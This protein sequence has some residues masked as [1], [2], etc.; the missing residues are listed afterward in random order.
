MVQTI[1]F[2]I[3]NI[4]NQ[5]RGNK[6]CIVM[7]G[8]FDTDDT[9]ARMIREVCKEMRISG[10]ANEAVNESVC[11]YADQKA[12]IVQ[13]Q[14]FP[15]NTD[16]PSGAIY[17]KSEVLGTVYPTYNAAG[18][19]HGT[20]APASL[21]SNQSVQSALKTLG[22]YFGPY[23]GSL[24]SEASKKAIRNFQTVYGLDCTGTM[25]QATLSKLDL[26]DGF[27]AR[28][29]DILREN[30][31]NELVKGLDY[32]EKE[33]FANIW[34]FLRLGMKLDATHASAV[35]A[36]I[37][38]ES[39]FSSDNLQDEGV[40]THHDPDYVYDVNDKKGYGIMQWTHPQRK[41]GLLNQAKSM[42]LQCSDLNAQLA[43]FRKEMNTAS[44]YKNQWTEFQNK[45]T[46]ND[47]TDYFLDEIENPDENNFQERRGFANTIYQFMYKL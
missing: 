42:G 4:Y 7:N 5:I 10:T 16:E 14:I 46:L 33:N 36:N 38:A 43:Y 13:N 21:P 6:D 17:E 3:W 41:Q 26:V 15:E 27:R 1:D 9:I 8:Y 39:G 12:N 29:A 18:S 2:D 11:L 45:K 44:L 20:I 34:A 24:T 28:A 47:A 31:N 40:V 23:D 19:I 35:M 25:N 37:N 22:F 32:Y 30:A